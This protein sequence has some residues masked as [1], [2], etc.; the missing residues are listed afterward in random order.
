MKCIFCQLA[1]GALPAAVVHETSTT[2]AL[3]DHHPAARGHTLILPR[4]HVPSLLHLN[5]G[6]AGSFFASLIEVTERLT[7]TLHP[8]ALEVRWIHGTSG[9]RDDSHFHARLVP[10]FLNEL[11]GPQT[12]GGY[13]SGEHLT[14]IAAIIRGRGADLWSRLMRARVAALGTARSDDGP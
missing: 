3:L 8:P 2:I 7:E 10:R 12:L 4:R 1:S 5:D 11:A 14:D 13:E 6:A 9:G